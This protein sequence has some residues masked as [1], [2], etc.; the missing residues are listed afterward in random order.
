MSG[1][2][3]DSM[4]TGVDRSVKSS[5]WLICPHRHESIETLDMKTDEVKSLFI[6]FVS[7]VAP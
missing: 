5:E 3:A 2:R 6:G 7:L 4:N 1:C